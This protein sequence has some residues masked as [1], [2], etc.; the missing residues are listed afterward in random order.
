MI[1]ATPQQSRDYLKTIEA[2]AVTQD[3]IDIKAHEILRGLSELDMSD[4]LYDSLIHIRNAMLVT[5]D[6]RVVGQI[7]DNA[8]WGYCLRIAR[9]E[10]E[11]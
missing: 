10:L 2:P 6:K 3:Q 7:V 11:A 8:V 1:D 9:T 5:D 4:A